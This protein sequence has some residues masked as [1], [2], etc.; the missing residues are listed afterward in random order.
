MIN[1]GDNHDGHVIGEPEKLLLIDKNTSFNKRFWA[2]YV[3]K[4]MLGWSGGGGADKMKSAAPNLK[5]LLRRLPWG[6]RDKARACQCRR[7]GF[8][9]WSRNTPRASE[10]VSPRRTTTEAVLCRPGVAAAEPTGHS[11]WSPCTLEPVLHNKRSHSDEKPAH[12][13]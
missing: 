7:H 13:S 4:R 5:K 2:C 10:Q 11:S 12:G 6:L 9:P 8:K 3:P 1:N